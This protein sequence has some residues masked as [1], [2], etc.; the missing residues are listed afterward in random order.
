MLDD[1]YYFLNSYSFFN[2]KMSLLDWISQYKETD[3]LPFLRVLIRL[4]ERVTL[5]LH[6]IHSEVDARLGDGFERLVVKI[7]N[8]FATLNN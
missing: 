3:D 6:G 5:G 4:H 8:A 1:L 2:E 7:N